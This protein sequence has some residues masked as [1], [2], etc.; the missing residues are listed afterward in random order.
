MNALTA[1]QKSALMEMK[2]SGG[3]FIWKPTMMKR[4]AAIERDDFRLHGIGDLWGADAGGAEAVIYVALLEMKG[5]LD[6][7]AKAKGEI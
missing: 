4:L 1:A 3:A 2:K 7:I 6:A 5:R